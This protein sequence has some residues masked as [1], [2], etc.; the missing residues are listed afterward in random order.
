LTFFLYAPDLDEFNHMIRVQLGIG[1]TSKMNIKA[2]QKKAAE[3]VNESKKSKHTCIHGARTHILF[4]DLPCRFSFEALLASSHY[5]RLLSQKEKE[6]AA[7]KNADAAA[8]AK[9][10]K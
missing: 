10:K 3:E 7:A 6:D 2:E 8:A 9:K 1:H 4:H 5:G